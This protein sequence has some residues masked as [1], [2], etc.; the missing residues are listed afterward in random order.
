[1]I[2]HT[3]P[4]GQWLC[5]NQT[6]HALMAMEFCRH[7]GNGDFAKPAPYDVVMSAIAQHDNGWYEWEAAPEVDDHGAPLAF[8]PGPSYAGKLP[9]WQR[10]IDRAAAQHPYMGL[11]ASRHATLLYEG[12]LHQLAGE[13]RRA[14]AAFIAKQEHWTEEARRLLADDAELHHAAT[15]PVLMAHTRL[16]QFG[17]SSSLQVLMPWGHERRFAH[18]PVDFAGTYVPIRLRWEGQEISFDPWPFGVA[19]FSVSIHGRLLDPETFPSHTAYQAAL[20]AAPLHK[21]T[22]HVAPDAAGG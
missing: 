18:C 15:E 14:T 7:W 2:V 12:D 6:S 19:H 11:M 9:I 3:R 8:I 21:L 16:L 13:E 20:A 4:N 22:W 1:M 5:I 17:D 10:G